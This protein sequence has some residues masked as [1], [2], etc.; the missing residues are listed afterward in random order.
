[1]ADA[2]RLIVNNSAG[3]DAAFQ[4]ATNVSLDASNDGVGWVFQANSA[5]AI[6]HLGFRYGART[7]TPPTYRI[8]LQSPTAAGGLP[9]GTVLGGGSPASGTFTPPADATWDGTWQWVALTN[10]YTPSRGQL[11]VSA[12]EH[13]SGT[14]DGSNFSSFTRQVTGF[15]MDDG[16]PYS[17]ILT[18]G[19]WAKSTMPC[20]GYRTANGRYGY[21]GQS[22]YATNTAGT[23]GHRS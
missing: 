9:D 23:N 17:C 6:T 2:L 11:L 13:S 14:V 21:I 8:S 19:T 5:D 7:G 10:S 22:A 18:A 20:F 4:T 1:M 15:R 16:F 3:V 12:I